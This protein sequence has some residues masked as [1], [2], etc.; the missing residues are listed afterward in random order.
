M[1]NF[2]GVTWFLGKRKGDQ[3]SPTEYKGRNMR[4]TDKGG[5]GGGRGGGRDHKSLQSV[6]GGTGKFHRDT[7]MIFPS[8]PPG[9]ELIGALLQHNVIL[10]TNITGTLFGTKMGFIWK[11]IR[12][13]T[14]VMVYLKHCLFS[15]L[16]YTSDAKNPSMIGSINCNLT[17]IPFLTTLAF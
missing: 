2:C 15:S 1:E 5:S 6:R 3:S 7:T 14:D 12:T 9:H 13:Q 17:F 11:M 10:S 16:R 4:I 8:P